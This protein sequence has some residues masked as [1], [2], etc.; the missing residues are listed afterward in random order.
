[1]KRL[2]LLYVNLLVISFFTPM[3]AQSNVI[4]Y[5]VHDVEN[6]EN[7]Y[8]NNKLFSNC[9]ENYDTDSLKSTDTI[10]GE[11]NFS[12]YLYSIKKEKKNKVVLGD[13]AHIDLASTMGKSL[14][15][16]EA[17]DNYNKNKTRKPKKEMVQ[18]V[19]QSGAKVDYKG[20]DQF[21]FNTLIHIANQSPYTI[22]DDTTILLELCKE[23][24]IHPKITNLCDSAIIIVDI[25]YETDSCIVIP[26]EN[27]LKCQ[28]NKIKPKTSK[29]LNQ[30]RY[31][32]P[33]GR[34]S[35]VHVYWQI[36]E[37]KGNTPL[38]LDYKK[39]IRHRSCYSL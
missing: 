38:K 31:R 17:I 36:W 27:G 39:P 26:V 20:D 4:F 1:M 33:Q 11:G 12:L 23:N 10:R 21:Y 7:V 6:K 18:S 13:A 3:L 28:V 2:V 35:V 25:L 29:L 8:I 5:K 14:T 22:E 32:V 15:I 30:S 34:H 9:I 37:G 16:G 19:V 24:Y